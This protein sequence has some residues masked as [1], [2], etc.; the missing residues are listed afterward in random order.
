[1]FISDK[2]SIDPKYL[3][4]IKHIKKEN[5]NSWVMCYIYGI[6]VSTFIPASGGKMTLHSTFASTSPKL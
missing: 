5:L 1:M 4:K 3:K 6:F 2:K